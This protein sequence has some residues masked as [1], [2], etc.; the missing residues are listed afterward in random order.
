MNKLNSFKLFLLPNSNLLAI[1]T[2]AAAAADPRGCDC[3]CFPVKNSFDDVIINEHLK[4]TTVTAGDTVW[5][6]GRVSDM[7][8]CRSILWGGD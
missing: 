4:L 5:E 8:E 2:C 7:S 6:L 3:L 1:V